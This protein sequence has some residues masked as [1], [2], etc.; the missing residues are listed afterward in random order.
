MTLEACAGNDCSL[1][2]S[3]ADIASANARANQVL[4]APN[5]APL[6]GAVPAGLTAPSSVVL[7]ASLFATAFTLIR[8]SVDFYF[9][10]SAADTLTFL[11]QEIPS[12]T[13]IAGGAVTG[14]WHVENGGT[15]VSLTG[16]SPSTLNTLVK[17]VPAGGLSDAFNANLVCIT[18]G[19][20]VGIQFVISASHNL[21]AMVLNAVISVV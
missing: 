12:A 2:A 5:V 14:T 6:L 9:T 3:A 8:V 16:G 15:A 21:S 11:I 7:A 13:A 19:P 10:D 17:T 20:Q 1:L 4:A 18:S